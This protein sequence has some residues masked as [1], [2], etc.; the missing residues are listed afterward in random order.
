M[1]K[2]FFETFK[3]EFAAFLLVEAVRRQSRDVAGTSSL[4][5]TNE[6]LAN[7]HPLDAMQAQLIRDTLLE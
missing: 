4:A 6:T 5:K 2:T 3:S 7:R 1:S